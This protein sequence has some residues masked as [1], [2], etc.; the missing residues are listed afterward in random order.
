MKRLTATHESGQ[1]EQA[2]SAHG[3]GGARRNKDLNAS[4]SGASDRRQFRGVN[5]L[6]LRLKKNSVVVELKQPLDHHQHGQQEQPSQDLLDAGHE[7][8]GL[9]LQSAPEQNS[10]S[11]RTSSIGQKFRFLQKLVHKGE[12]RGHQAKPAFIPYT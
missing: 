6:A 3:T 8:H 9:S 5:P 11:A 12:Q 2:I 4:G 7:S 10:T 1:Y